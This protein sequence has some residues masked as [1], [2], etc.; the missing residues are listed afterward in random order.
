VLIGLLVEAKER[1]FIIDFVPFF[2]GAMKTGDT[3]GTIDAP[4]LFSSG[5]RWTGERKFFWSDNIG[6]IGFEADR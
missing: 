3:Q 6:C 1:S 2:V 4:R 5:A